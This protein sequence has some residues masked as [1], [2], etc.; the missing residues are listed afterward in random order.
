M[1][2][3][4]QQLAKQLSRV[5]I[6][7]PGVLHAIATVPRHLFVPAD[8]QAVAYIDEALPI[9]HRQTISQPYVVA[10]MTEL[11]LRDGPVD[12][13]LEIGTGSG[14]QAAIL[15]SLIPQVFT[16]ERIQP[17]YEDAKAVFK[18]LGLS[19]IQCLLSSHG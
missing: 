1:E 10:K 17:L 6:Q 13:A 7:H 12:K 2:N 18:D 19:N 16:I 14:Y 8:L 15:A 4:G 9:K 3:S 5:G 11:I